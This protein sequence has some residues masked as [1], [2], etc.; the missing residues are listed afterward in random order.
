MT[1]HKP[2]KQ[3]KWKIP[4]ISEVIAE[5]PTWTWS[6]KGGTKKR[7]AYKLKKKIFFKSF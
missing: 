6:I 3:K 1:G 2:G 5:F 4:S 7:R